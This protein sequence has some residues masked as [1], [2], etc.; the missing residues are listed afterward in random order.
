MAQLSASTVYGKLKAT[1]EIITSKITTDSLNGADIANASADD[2][3]VSNGDGTLT[4]GDPGSGAKILVDDNTNNEHLT[5]IPGATDQYYGNVDP[6]NNGETLEQG[7]VWID[8][9]E[10]YN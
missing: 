5:K 6:N 10:A 3:P 9:S 2:V 4:M 7:D 8:T 1:T